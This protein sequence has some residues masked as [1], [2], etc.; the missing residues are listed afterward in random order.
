MG[1]GGRIEGFGGEQVVQLGDDRCQL[2]ADAFGARRQRVAVGSADQQLVSEVT[3]Q[4]LQSPAHRGLAER[5]PVG[6]ARDVALLQQ[7]HQR[8]Q[9]VQIDAIDMRRAAYR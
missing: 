7:G 3:P 8:R 5:E 6:G 1:R 9:Q 4:P 2:G